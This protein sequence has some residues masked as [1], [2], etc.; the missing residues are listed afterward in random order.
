MTSMSERE[1]TDL[2]DPRTICPY[3]L[4][5]T[6]RW[7][8]AEPSREHVCTAAPEPI[9]VGLDTQR[10]LCFGDHPACERYQAAV[11]AYRAAVPLLPL[12]PIART[13]PVVVDRGRAP[14]PLPSIANRRALGQAILA[15]VMVAAVAAVLVARLGGPAGGVLGPSRSPSSLA[16]ASTVALASPSPSAAASPTPPPTAA[17]T[18]TPKASPS[19]NPSPSASPSAAT[20]RTYTV[21]SGD[22]LS[23]IAAHFGTTV[24][25]LSKLNGISNPSLIKPGQVLKLP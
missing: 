10:R 9:P 18:A 11:T 17:P 14:F 23:S 19:P 25:I 22:T 20:G 1:T 13:A 12:R 2:A 21:K 4:V 15:L 16:S 8:N 3:L 24:K 5:A 6:G 7:R